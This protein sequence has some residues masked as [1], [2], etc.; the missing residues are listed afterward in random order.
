LDYAENTDHLESVSQLVQVVVEDLA[1]GAA[2]VRAARLFTVSSVQ[3]LIPKIRENTE[4]DK[5]FWEHAY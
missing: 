4:S 3:G 5:P 2:V 1:E